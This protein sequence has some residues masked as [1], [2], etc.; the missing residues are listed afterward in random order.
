MKSS[1]P[2]ECPDH[3]GN[4]LFTLY[5]SLII[6]RHSLSLLFTHPFFSA[7]LSPLSFLV[8]PSFCYPLQHSSFKSPSFQ[9]QPSLSSRW[10]PVGQWRNP[11]AG[12][13]GVGACRA[14]QRLD[15]HV[16]A[17]LF[18]LCP[19]AKENGGNTEK[20]SSRESSGE[21][22]GEEDQLGCHSCVEVLGSLGLK[23]WS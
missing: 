10:C 6:H 9:F 20:W 15:T 4:P 19:S 12:L 2:L 13:Q 18:G 5:S 21:E 16:W 23:L 7:L 8:I 14:G 22:G 1:F 3:C 11:L 17:W